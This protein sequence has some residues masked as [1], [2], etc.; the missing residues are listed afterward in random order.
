MNTIATEPRAGIL[1]D[2]QRS[3]KLVLV[4]VLAG[5]AIGAGLSSRQPERFEST[6]NVYLLSP[7]ELGIFRSQGGDADR[8]LQREVRTAGSRDVATRASELLGGT[9]SAKDIDEHVTITPAAALDLFQVRAR[10]DSG[11]QAAEMANA[12]V[13]AYRAERRTDG[14]ARALEA[15]DQLGAFQ[16]DLRTRLESTDAFLDQLRQTILAGVLGD[17]AVQQAALDADPDY[18]EGVAR[19]NALLS[20]SL[21]I[22]ARIGEIAADAAVAGDGVDFTEP[23]AVPKHAASPSPRRDALIGLVLGLVVAAVLARFRAERRAVED[24]REQAARIGVRPLGQIPTVRR[25]GSEEDPEATAAYEVLLTAVL[26]SVTTDRPRS[27]LVCGPSAGVGASTVAAN[28]ALIANRKGNP[29]TLIDGDLKQRALTR[30]LSNDD[31]VGIAQIARDQCEPADAEHLVFD[32][33][34]IFGFLAAGR[35]SGVGRDD[36]AGWSWAPTLAKLAVGNR[37]LVIDGPPVLGPVDALELAAT[38]G[39]VVVVTSEDVQGGALGETVSRLELVNANIAGVVVNS[40]PR[41]RR[42]RQPSQQDGLVGPIVVRAPSVLGRLESGRG[43]L[44]ERP[45]SG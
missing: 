11:R 6:A 35:R 14:E 40:P 45:T 36:R 30:T 9:V 15:A 20:Q 17:L 28:L 23:A 10:A 43:V 34:N 37:L 13:E 8:R 2:L 32:G 18:A 4:L 22:E 44:S 42:V 26:R 3:W 19:R 29:T 38:V 1:A 41:R 12:V 31:A 21:A 24:P 39:A 27:V 25:A 33:R 7:Q 5:G 16:E